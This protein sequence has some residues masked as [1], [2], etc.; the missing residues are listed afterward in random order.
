MKKFILSIAMLATAAFSINALTFEEFFSKCETISGQSAM[1]ISGESVPELQEAKVISVK[2]LAINPASDNVIASISEA[3]K[4]IT[5]TEETISVKN[6]DEDENNREYI[7]PS[8][9]KAEILVININNDKKEC[10][11]VKVDGDISILSNPN[12]HF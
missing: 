6:N 11:V 7:L 2:V 1:T 8:E 4:E 3:A 5:V 9:D 10:N 12:F